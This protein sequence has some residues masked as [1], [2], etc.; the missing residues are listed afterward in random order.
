VGKRGNNS[1]ARQVKS[2]LKAQKRG[3][4]PQTAKPDARDFLR[5]KDRRKVLIASKMCKNKYE[6]SRRKCG[7]R[8]EKFSGGAYRFGRVRTFQT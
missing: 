3:F 6:M 8:E 5:A 7:L 2:K 1:L 4:T